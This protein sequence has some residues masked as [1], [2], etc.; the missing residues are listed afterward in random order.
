MSQLCRAC[1]TYVAK[2]RDGI[3]DVTCRDAYD[4]GMSEQ[5]HN[6][7]RASAILRREW[8]PEHG[9]SCAFIEAVRSS[10]QNNHAPDCRYVRV[11]DALKG[12]L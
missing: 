4:L 8:P 2:G 10:N 9:D 6:F 11:R 12:L 7:A 1:L 5:A 3:C